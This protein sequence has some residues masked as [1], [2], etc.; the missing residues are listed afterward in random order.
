MQLGLL[1]RIFNKT[2]IYSVI[3]NMGGKNTFS[4][5]LD[6]FANNRLTVLQSPNKGRLCGYGMAPEG[7]ESNEMVFELITDAEWKMSRWT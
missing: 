7:V 1:Q 3:P 4:G 2:W 6:F 5:C